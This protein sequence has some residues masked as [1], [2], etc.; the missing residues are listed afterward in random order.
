MEELGEILRRS[1]SSGVEEIVE[2][3]GLNTANWQWG[4]AHSITHKHELGKFSTLNWIFNL[5]VGSYPSGG[6]DKSPNAGGY[7]FSSVAEDGGW[8][9]G[10]GGSW[11]SGSMPYTAKT[12]NLQSNAY[13]LADSS[14]YD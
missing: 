12:I 5:N 2:H 1:F 10:G 4:R 9:G 13:I 6:S 8:F 7:S 14:R 3:V 11:S